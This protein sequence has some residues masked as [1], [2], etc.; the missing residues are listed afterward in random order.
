M[1]LRQPE[2]SQLPAYS[3]LH[4]FADTLLSMQNFGA[5]EAAS[6]RPSLSV[7]QSGMGIPDKVFKKDFNFKSR[8]FKNRIT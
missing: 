5:T 6:R 4:S 3:V 1:N 7:T 8:E 2:T